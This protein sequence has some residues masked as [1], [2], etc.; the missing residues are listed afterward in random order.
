M[1]AHIVTADEKGRVAV[2]EY[3][4]PALTD[5]DVRA[6]S[7]ASGISHGTEMHALEGGRAKYP[8]RLGYS[9]VGRVTDVGAKVTRCRP[10][11]LIFAYAPHS[12]A[13][14]TNEER[15]WPLEKDV[16]P[17]CGQFLALLSVTYNGVMEARPV[18]G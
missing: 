15:C 13:F 3:A 4:L 11:D 18:L 6:T 8:V 2:V 17:V 12:T 5:H 1:N 9:A 16:A 10:G 14:Q 7:L